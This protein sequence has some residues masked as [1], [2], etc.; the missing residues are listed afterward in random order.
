MHT[1]TDVTCRVQSRK[2]P[3]GELTLWSSSKRWQWG[4]TMPVM[5]DRHQ[6]FHVG[7]VPEATMIYQSITSTACYSR[8]NVAPTNDHSVHQLWKFHL[9]V[10]AVS[11]D[12]LRSGWVLSVIS[13]G[14]SAADNVSLSS[15]LVVSTSL[16]SDQMPFKWREEISQAVCSVCISLLSVFFFF[17][18]CD[19]EINVLSPPVHMCWLSRA[20]CWWNVKCTCYWPVI[21]CWVFK[22]VVFIAWLR[23]LLQ[24]LIHWFALVDGNFLA[25]LHSLWFA[26]PVLAVA[27]KY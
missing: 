13:S 9:A 3:K 1:Q 21:L 25:F 11:A 18:V 6:V 24:E 2:S 23:R 4:R 8:G 22:R 15:H 7:V 26:L 14:L 12:W 20:I 16:C 17:S 27:W 5:V 10:E 19:V